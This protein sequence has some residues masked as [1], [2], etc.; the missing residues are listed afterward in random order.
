MAYT[1]ATAASLKA[2]FP[3]FAAVADAT[4]DAWLDRARRSVDQS[5]T[6]GDYTYAQELLAAHYMTLEGLGT[7]TESELNAQ[8]LGD[9]KSVRSGSFSFTRGD[10]A[11]SS[12]TGALGSTAYGRQWYAL[13]RANRGGPRTTPTG[14]IPD[15]Q[16]YPDTPFIASGS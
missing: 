12:A 6:E 15:S 10:S 1:D 13:A 16:L 4:V 8:G 5:W 9:F 2:T 14:T 7:G 11:D 3:R